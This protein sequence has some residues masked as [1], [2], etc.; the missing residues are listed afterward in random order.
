LQGPRAAGVPSLLDIK[1][2]RF[3]R[4]GQAAIALALQYAGVGSAD[5][6]LVPTY[7]CPSMVSPIVFFGTV[8]RY[9][10]IEEQGAPHRDFL[11]AL[12]T[13]KVR[14]LIAAHYFGVPQDFSWLRTWCDER[15]VFFIEDCAHAFFGHAQGRQVGAWG[16][17][18]I[19]SLPKFFPVEDGG[20]LV[21]A[22][23]SLDAISLHSQPLFTD[24]KRGADMLQLG[25]RYRRLPGLNTLVNAVFGTKAALHRHAEDQRDGHETESVEAAESFVLPQTLP[26]VLIH[27][28][29]RASRLGLNLT[30]Q[31]RVVQRRRENYA[32]LAHRLSALPGAKPLCA[33]LPAGAVPYVFPLRV[34]QNADGRYRAL[35]LI[36]FPLFRWDCPWPGTPTLTGE[37]GAL[38][39]HE[40]FQLACHQDLRPA[41]IEQMSDTLNA[42]FQENS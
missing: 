20:C 6:V 38:W 27:T 18:A 11:A 28:A 10:P 2:K 9:F 23:H 22:H 8:P 4:S 7:H 36:N 42:V 15:K 34:T 24:I 14:A 16:D 25:A 5:E 39:A 21:S 29:T 1:E 41:D 19:G 32:Q 31:Q 3:S 37:A 12:D 13:K 35:R 33:E 30:A 40:V 17:V 26:R